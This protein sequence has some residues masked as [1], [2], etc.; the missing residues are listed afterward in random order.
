MRAL[1]IAGFLIVLISV[2]SS[3]EF[4]Q[5]ISGNASLYTRVDTSGAHSA[6]NATGSQDYI[7]YIKEDKSKLRLDSIYNIRDGQTLKRDSGEGNSTIENK[8]TSA[9]NKKDVLDNY[10]M[11]KMDRPG[12]MYHFVEI[13]SNGS[14]NSNNTIKSSDNEAS[15]VFNV[16]FQS[17]IIEERVASID[18]KKHRHSMIETQT[19]GI[20][21]LYSSHL[22][23]DTNLKKDDLSEIDQQLNKLESAKLS[24]EI[25]KIEEQVVGQETIYRSPYGDIPFTNDSN[26]SSVK[27]TMVEDD[28][29]KFVRDS[30]QQI[31]MNNLNQRYASEKDSS[32]KDEDDSGTNSNGNERN[33]NDANDFELLEDNSPLIETEKEIFLQPANIYK[34]DACNLLN[35]YNLI[36]TKDSIYFIKTEI[37]EKHFIPILSK[38]AYK[39]NTTKPIIDENDST[40]GTELI[41][42]ERDIYRITSVMFKQYIL[43]LL[44]IYSTKCDISNQGISDNGNEKSIDGGETDQNTD[45]YWDQG[46]IIEA[47]DGLYYLAPDIYTEEIEKKLGIV[48]PNTTI[49]AFRLGRNIQRIVITPLGRKANTDYFKSEQVTIP[50]SIRNQG[51]LTGSSIN[52]TRTLSTSYIDRKK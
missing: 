29:P 21:D 20:I 24:G 22:V 46:S 6:I 34:D 19:K 3:E 15:T 45:S 50:S 48:H 31:E 37:C 10:Y 51:N 35:D 23:D 52:L 25:G 32:N 17:G 5:L 33:S 42:T 44:D 11:I 7:L 9:D 40:N 39:V 2:S 30:I 27:N 47:N 28:R 13:H 26:F 14:I 36:E 12:G 49:D 8:S 43:P 38:L 41:I 1:I 18:D 16:S 4:S